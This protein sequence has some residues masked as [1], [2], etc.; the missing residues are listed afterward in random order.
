[1]NFLA[2]EMTFLRYF[3]PLIIC[4]NKKNIKS[5]VLIKRNNK[6][7]C[8]IKNIQQLE[9]LS[10]KYNFNLQHAS[11]ANQDTTFLI[12]GVGAN[13]TKAK[14]ISMT[15]MT[16]YT[17]SWKKY[18]GDIDYCIFP[19]KWFAK[20]IKKENDEKSLFL[21]SPKYD[22]K[23]DK[24]NIFKKYGL[25][26]DFKYAFI[27]LPRARDLNLVNLPFI[28]NFLHDKGYKIITKSRGKDNYKGDGDF[29]FLDVSWFPHDSMELMSV[30]DLVINFDSTCIKECVMAR[31]KVINFNLKPFKQ[32]LPEL[33]N[34]KYSANIKSDFWNIKNLNAHY[35]RIS[36][37]D[38]SSFD[39]VIEKY[40]FKTGSSS[41]I[42]D[43]FD[44]T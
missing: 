16:D 19:S 29:N 31:K 28:Y 36:A 5:T 25:N 34:E 30:S 35:E 2:L 20:S 4:G 1:M 44:I 14:K 17:L 18:W 37:C 13:L 8:P 9:A 26:T 3:I 10:D 40:L 43:Y 32:L 7:N 22:L 15:Y 41:R 23:F 27:P 11:E 6:Y 12:E 33:Y 24:Q 42:L 38:D 21:G 39:H